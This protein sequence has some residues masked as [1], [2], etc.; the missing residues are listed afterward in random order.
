MSGQKLVSY[1]H[2]F[3]MF[4]RRSCLFSPRGSCV[5]SYFFPF[6]V[7]VDPAEE[8]VRNIFALKRTAT[9]PSFAREEK[10]VRLSVY[11][12]SGIR[13]YLGGCIALD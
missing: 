7:E 2:P 5:I 3:F 4:S 9:F 1:G 6:R 12:Q 11:L 8:R 13:N 10:N